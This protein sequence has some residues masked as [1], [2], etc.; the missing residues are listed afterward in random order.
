MPREQVKHAVRLNIDA[1]GY[2]ALIAALKANQSSVNESAVE[3]ADDLLAK[4]NRYTRF[5]TDDEGEGAE[6]RF[7]ESEAIRLIMLLLQAFAYYSSDDEDYY[8][9]A[10]NVEMSG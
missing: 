8:H 9:N 7:F 1:N 5:Y 4:I 3:R 10:N 6:I 2:N